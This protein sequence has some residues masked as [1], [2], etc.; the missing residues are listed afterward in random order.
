MLSRNGLFVY[1]YKVLYE[2][3][4][5]SLFDAKDDGREFPE[6]SVAKGEWDEARYKIR[7]PTWPRRARGLARGGQPAGPGVL[8]LEE[9]ENEKGARGPAHRPPLGLARYRYAAIA[10]AEGGPFSVCA[11]SRIP[12]RLSE[13]PFAATS[14]GPGRARHPGAGARGGG[15]RLLV[16]VCHWK[17]KSEGAEAT[18]E[19][20]REAATLVSDLVS[21]RLA[22]DPGAAIVVCGDLN[23][24]PDEYARVGRR[25]PTALMPVEDPAAAGGRNAGAR[26]P[27]RRFG[28]LR[29]P[30]FGA[31]PSLQSL[32][33]IG[34]L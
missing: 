11:L 1:T 19:A 16:L 26:S 12:V 20:R 4:V 8:C 9:I 15:G 27:P 22:A 34:R 31:S 18:E 30:A 17:S 32:A 24:S 7:L 28:A 33:G 6:Y 2:N 10:P 3:N 29:H 14:G 13:L 5:K 21:A 23:E 25:Y